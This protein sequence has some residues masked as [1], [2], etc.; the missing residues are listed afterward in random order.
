VVVAKGDA[1]GALPLVAPPWSVTAS[2]AYQRE[3]GSTHLTLSAQGAFHSRNPGPF[4]SHNALAV[5]YAP[6]R[7]ANPATNV[8][9]LRA[10]ATWSAFELTLFVQN[11]FDSRPVLQVRNHISTDTLLYATTFRPRT[12]GVAAKWRLDSRSRP[13]P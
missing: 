10:S 11:A 13:L 2:L 8:V 4:S 9:N 1:V 5:T 3:F 7:Q 12:L 6:A